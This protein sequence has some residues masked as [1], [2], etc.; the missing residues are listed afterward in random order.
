MGSTK[1]NPFALPD[2]YAASHH[3]N[4]CL[5]GYLSNILIFYDSVGLIE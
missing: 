3:K 5:P 4:V 2:A 1:D